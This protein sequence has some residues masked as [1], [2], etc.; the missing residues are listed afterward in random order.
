MLLTDTHTYCLIGLS[1]LHTLL[2]QN[3]E[4]IVDKSVINIKVSCSIFNVGIKD[5]KLTYFVSVEDL[6]T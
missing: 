5:K 2:I 4:Y 6:C 1:F 3:W